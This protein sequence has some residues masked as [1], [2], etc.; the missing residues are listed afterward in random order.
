MIDQLENKL[1]L[2]EIDSF[3]IQIQYSTIIEVL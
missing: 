2:L 3:H 1:S